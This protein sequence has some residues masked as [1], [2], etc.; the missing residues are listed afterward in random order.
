MTTLRKD[1]S[2]SSSS[3]EELVP[4]RR[5]P[6]QRSPKPPQLQ[7]T[8]DYDPHPLQLYDD[9]DYLG[10][11]PRKKTESPPLIALAAQTLPTPVPI[12]LTPKQPTN[13]QPAPT[14][15]IAPELV[16]EPAA[17]SPLNTHLYMADLD[18]RRS[19]PKAVSKAERDYM[20]RHGSA[21]GRLRTRKVQI[22]SLPGS[23]KNSRVVERLDVRVG[24]QGRRKR[25]TILKKA[26]PLSVNRLGDLMG[27][28]LGSSRS[29]RVLHTAAG[30]R[31]RH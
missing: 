12:D 24:T 22:E 23:Q 27:A 11:R 28:Y 15:F 4:V 13:Q 9:L 14:F 10:R 3:G 18:L 25:R 21:E 19:L 1:T 30:N 20:I 31:F 8:D 16:A 29:A 6:A 26:A 7:Q 17:P 5:R 2:S